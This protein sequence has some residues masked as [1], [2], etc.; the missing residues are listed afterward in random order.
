MKK[1]E[2]VFDVVCKNT[3]DPDFPKWPRTYSGNPI[4]PKT[5]PTGKAPIVYLYFWLDRELDKRQDEFEPDDLFYLGER[6]SVSHFRRGWIPGRKDERYFWLPRAQNRRVFAVIYEL[7]LASKYSRQDK[8]RS[9]EYFVARALVDRYGMHHK[10][11]LRFTGR[12]DFR[13]AWLRATD[14]KRHAQSILEDL[15]SCYGI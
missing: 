12:F 15:K 8:R 11:F 4:A 3:P 9:L 2:L 1:Q 13:V 7:P 5:W 14:V 10:R 6:A